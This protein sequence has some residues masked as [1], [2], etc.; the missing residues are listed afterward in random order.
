MAV[1]ESIPR[2]TFLS[3]VEMASIAPLPNPILFVA[4]VTA[5][6]NPLMSEAPP[7]PAAA[8][9]V[10]PSVCAVST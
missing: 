6:L 5:S 1:P 7:P 9:A 4:D 3:P 10:V 2:P 8:H